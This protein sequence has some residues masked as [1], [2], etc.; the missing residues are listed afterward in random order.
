MSEPTSPMTD[1]DAAARYLDISPRTLS[2][3]VAK[4]RIPYVKIG[5]KLR[6]KWADLDAY[7]EQQTVPVGGRR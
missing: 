7:I 5:R 2:G 4:R 6:F 3:W 1:L